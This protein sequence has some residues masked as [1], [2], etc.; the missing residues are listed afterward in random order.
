M[1]DPRVG[2]R[3]LLSSLSRICCSSW[4]R[5]RMRLVCQMKWTCVVT[6]ARA[7]T[8]KETGTNTQYTN[9]QTINNRANKCRRGTH[10]VRRQYRHSTQH[11]RISVHRNNAPT[12]APTLI[13]TSLDDDCDVTI[14]TPGSCPDGAAKHEKR[15]QGSSNNNHIDICM[16]V[17]M[18]ACDQ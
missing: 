4:R 2:N 16:Y 18:H 6:R 17:R 7:V 15:K 10:L 1:F 13:A 8:S 11:R 12:I 14:V 9:K 5:L 3:G